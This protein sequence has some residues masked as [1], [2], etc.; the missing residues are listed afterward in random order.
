[1]EQWRGMAYL[2]GAFTLAGSSV[3]AA[4]FIPAT[5]GIFR[6]T[7]MSLFL[8]ILCLLPLSWR[9]VM[10]A[11][12]QLTVR[13]WGLLTLQALFGIVLFR[14]FFLY[15][16]PLT[17]AAEAGIL[18]GATPAVTVMLAVALLKERITRSAFMG[19]ASTI[20]GILLVQGLLT[21]GAGDAFSLNHA[22]GNILVLCAAVSE[23]LFN[24][25]SRSSAVQNA[26]GHRKPLHP[27]AQTTLVTFI[28]WLLCLVPSYFEQPLSALFLIGWREWLALFWYGPIVTALAFLFWYAGIKRCHASTAAALSGM[29]PFTA[30]LLSVV[31]LGET[32]GRQQWTGGGLIVL[33][34]ALIGVSQGQVRNVR[35]GIN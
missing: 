11:I 24:V 18:T 14:M 29:M 35:E 25:I 16:L 7:A 5:L 34:M 20:G 33:G 21:P 22:A 12:R 19:I 10:G 4:S 9:F 8:A 31:V 1:M 15:G 2:I 26:V 13:D 6:I 28:A 23:S 30:L 32:A 27:L 3:I 17:S